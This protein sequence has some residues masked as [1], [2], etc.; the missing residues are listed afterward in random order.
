MGCNGGFL[1]GFGDNN[2]IWIILI[3]ILICCCCND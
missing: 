3:I 1:G 2:C